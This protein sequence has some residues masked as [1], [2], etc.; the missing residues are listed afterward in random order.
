MDRAPKGNVAP[1]AVAVIGLL[2]QQVFETLSQE[3]LALWPG[4]G[5]CSMA[6]CGCGIRVRVEGEQRR[7]VGRVRRLNK[8]YGP[9]FTAA[10][11]QEVCLQARVEHW[12]SACLDLRGMLS[13]GRIHIFF[14]P[15]SRPG[16]SCEVVSAARPSGSF[17][18]GIRCVCTYVPT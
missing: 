7:V 14:S 16:H 3:V 10:E 1:R 8:H 15:R 2:Q 9:A 13:L 4:R 6:M 17:S 12:L 18:F 11:E 5:R